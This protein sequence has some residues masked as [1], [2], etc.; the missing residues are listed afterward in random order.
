MPQRRPGAMDQLRSQLL[1][2][3]LA[4]A[5]HPGPAS[6]GV[7]AGRKAEPRRQIAGFGEGAA[8]A[9]GG[10]Q[11]GGVDHTHPR[12]AGKPTRLFVAADNCGE[13]V[14]IGFDSPTQA[15]AL[16]EQ[17]LHKPAGAVADRQA[18]RA[19]LFKPTH[20]DGATFGQRD[21]TL[22]QHGGKLVDRTHPV[23]TAAARL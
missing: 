15:V 19:N 20:E 14:I 11:S 23:R 5:E 13:F 4:D 21:S 3:P 7:L 2:S 9:H 22:Q 12:D 6:G 18:F 1:I 10:E 8:I 16:L 17:V